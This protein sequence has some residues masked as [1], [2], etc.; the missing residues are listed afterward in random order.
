MSMLAISAAELASMRADAAEAACDQVCSIDR[1]TRTPDL[2]SGG[3]TLT[4]PT[5]E[6]VMAGMTEPTAS[7]L[8]N[9]GYLVGSKAAW[10]VRFPV[11]TSV[12]ENDR[13][14]INGETLEVAK[15]MQPRS[16]TALVTVLAV[17]VK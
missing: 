4:W 9:Y 14:I 13:L 8:T 3:A 16:Y 10:Q 5:I 11:G 17:E 7:Q 6:T 12:L 15:V 2:T 1:S